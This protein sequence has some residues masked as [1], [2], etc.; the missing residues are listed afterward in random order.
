ME[1]E[2]APT[3]SETPGPVHTQLDL[4]F[5]ALLRAE[6]SGPNPPDTGVNEAPKE[7][8]PTGEEALK[9]LMEQEDL[10]PGLID[11]ISRMAVRVALASLHREALTNEREIHGLLH[12]CLKHYGAEG[13]F[14]LCGILEQAHRREPGEGWET[15]EHALPQSAWDPF[16][17]A[18]EGWLAERSEERKEIDD[19]QE[20]TAWE[21]ELVNLTRHPE[22]NRNGRTF[23]TSLAN[24]PT[25][26]AGLVEAGTL[27]ETMLERQKAAGDYVEHQVLDLHQ[28]LQVAQ[29][30]AEREYLL[31]PDEASAPSLLN[32]DSRSR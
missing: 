4:T 26:A 8:E 23:L 3:L 24:R 13:C 30:E 15:L 17:T 6:A 5:D 20:A 2:D 31:L 32:W 11:Y 28:D 16:R 9:R 25:L 18:A 19:S 12:Y 27:L 21:Q 14:H 10:D 1:R 22:V 29:V 7:P